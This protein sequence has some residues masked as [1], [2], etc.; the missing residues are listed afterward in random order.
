MPVVVSML[1]SYSGWAA[2]GIGF[3]L[4][5]LA[6]IITG[7][8]VGSSGAI[9][10]YIMCKG[11]N[12]SLHLGDP[13][14]LRR[15]DRR[16]A[17]AGAAEARPVK[18]GSAD[19][20]A[21]IMKNAAKVI[22]V[23]GYG[24]AVAQAQHS[25][26]EMA[27]MLKKEG[28]EVKYAIHPVAGRM[29]GHM[30][31]L[32]AEASVPYD[33]VFELEDINGEFAQADVA[34]VIGAND[35]TNPAA[36]TDPQSPIFGMPILDVEKAKTVLFI[37]RGMGSGYAGVENE[38]F[39]K[40]QHD[41]AVRRRQEDGRTDPQELR[42]NAA[43][44]EL[45]ASGAGCWR[46]AMT[47][48]ILR[49]AARRLPCLRA[50]SSSRSIFAQ[51][52]LQYPVQ[53]RQAPAA[54]A[55]LADFADVVLET[56]DGERLVG[57]WKPPAARQGADPLL[58]RQRR[59]PSGT[60]A[61][62]C[63][64]SRRAGAA[65][66]SSPIAAIRARPAGRRRRACGTDA[67]TGLRLRLGKGYEPSRIVVYGE[68]LGIGGRGAPRDGAAGRRASS[69][70]RPTHRPP[71]V[72]RLAYWYVPVAW[73][74]QDQFRSV[75]MIARHQGAASDPARRCATR[76]SRSGSARGSSRPRPSRSASCACPASATARP[77]KRRACGGRGIPRRDRGATADAD[78]RTL[79]RPPVRHDRHPANRT[80]GRPGSRHRPDPRAQPSRPTSPATASAIA[81]RRPPITTSSCS[82]SPAQ[83]ADR[84][85]RGG[86]RVVAAM[87]FCI[88]ED[89]AYVT[90]DVRR[91]GTVTDL[92]VRGGMARPG[93]RTHARS[94]RPSA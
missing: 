50:F 53:T 38:L 87:G 90:D 54:E 39:F 60:G 45:R 30:N 24:M 47:T 9:L 51:R 40:R 85:G 55:G 94:K 61:T 63:G 77:R 66:S 26:R 67:R 57:W 23:P 33:E 22:I 3:T 13:R 71:T 84:P 19:D 29:P 10:S 35:V 78:V 75:D 21:F 11:M 46:F 68:S 1:N 80:A 56:P 62:A 18:Q 48:L 83:R 36:K 81:R 28:V 5:N 86:G 17:A 43:A 8:L 79:D 2:A 65:C 42:L 4:G 52:S 92:V 41:D 82:A 16:A 70:T 12:R 49:V 6:L 7:A 74:M 15:R 76:R 59:A 93:R 91:H 27:D 64:R 89:A 14:R 20:A 69:S 37:K 88:D 34:F 58:P 32:L 73:L 72:A 25:L 44:S 31:V